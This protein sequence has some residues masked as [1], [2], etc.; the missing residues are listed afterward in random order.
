MDQIYDVAVIGAGPSG[1]QFD[2]VYGKLNIL[3]PESASLVKVQPM[4]CKKIQ[5]LIGPKTVFIEL[6]QSEQLLQIFIVKRNDPI[7]LIT[8]PISDIDALNKVQNL[9]V[10]LKQKNVLDVRSHDYIKEIRHPLT[11]LFDLI[12]EPLLPRLQDVEHIII[13]PHLFW[14]YFPFHALYNKKQKK[15]LCEQ[16]EISYCPTA[17]VLQLAGKRITQSE[18]AVL[19]WLSIMETCLM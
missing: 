15:Y 11:V 7:S 10:Q 14:H 18:T 17:S 5:N 4:P 19:F 1:G 12:V 2:R 9:L 6:F 16:F 8:I 3:E 13:S